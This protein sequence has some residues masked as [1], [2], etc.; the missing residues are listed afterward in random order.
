[1][2]ILVQETEAYSNS[3][4]D[5]LKKKRINRAQVRIETLPRTKAKGIHGHL[6]STIYTIQRPTPLEFVP[7]IQ[8]FMKLTHNIYP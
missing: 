5:A 1:M 7:L 6:Y 4:K 8:I 3:L 2:E